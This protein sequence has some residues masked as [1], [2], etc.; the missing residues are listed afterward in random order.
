MTGMMNLRALVEKTRVAD[1]LREMIGFA[2][3][4]TEMGVGPASGGILR[5]QP[6]LRTCGG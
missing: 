1:L 4:L 3:E 6:R 2:A 5:A